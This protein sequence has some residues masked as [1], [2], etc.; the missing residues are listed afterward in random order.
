M[1]RGAMTAIATSLYVVLFVL[2]HGSFQSECFWCSK[3]LI[4][5]VV[6]EGWNPAIPAL[7]YPGDLFKESSKTAGHEVLRLRRLN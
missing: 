3:P 6:H 1:Y 2:G 4:M 7:I 5:G